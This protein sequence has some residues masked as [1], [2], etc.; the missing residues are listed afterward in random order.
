M[1]ST[2]YKKKMVLAALADLYDRGFDRLVH[3]RL[4]DMSGM[5]ANNEIV[6]IPNISSLTTVATQSSGDDVTSISAQQVAPTGLELA[7]DQSRGV[8]IKEEDQRKQEYLDGNFYKMVTQ[9]AV[10]QLRSYV[11]ENIVSYIS[12]TLCYDTSAT[13]HVNVAGD[14][15]STA[16]MSMSKAQLMNNDGVKRLAYFMNPYAIASLEQ[17][18][19][20]VPNY[21]QA[22]N[23]NLGVPQIGSVNGVPVFE[24]NSIKR[25]RSITITASSIASNVATLTVAAGHGVVPGVKITT[26]GMTDDVDPAAAVTS[27]TATTIVVPLTASDTGD[28]GTG[29]ITVASCENLLVDLN[30]VY[31]GYQRPLP[32]VRMVDYTGATS[33]EIQIWTRWGRVGRA[34]RALVIHSPVNGA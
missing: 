22:E 7:A 21:T 20:F 5:L 16:D 6:E 34:G 30:H 3:N 11:D 33:T 31:C 27:V 12:E 10:E 17:I 8:F 32:T 13:Y 24:S 15:L 2:A 29:T 23:G 19:G 26:A 4:I 28:N 1:A 9:Q 25:N 14:A 18:T